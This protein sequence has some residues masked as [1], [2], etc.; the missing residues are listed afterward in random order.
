MI[1]KR[2]LLAAF[3]ALFLAGAPA[4][5]APSPAPQAA[6]APAQPENA[7]KTEQYTL[8]HDRYEKAVAFSR[9]QYTLYFVSF[10]YG[11]LILLLVLRLGVAAQFRNLA[12]RFSDRRLL[13][14]TL[15]VPLLFLTLDVLD[16]PLAAYRHSLSLRYELSVQGWGSW[17]WDWSK[18]EMIGILFGFL[19]VLILFAVIR[20]SPRRCW[21]YFW[22]AALPVALAAFFISPWVIDPLFNKFEPLDSR[23]PELVTAIEKVVHRAGLEIPR[24]KLF[25]MQAS[26]KSNAINAYVTGFGA[27][28]RVVVWDT[29]I[30]KTSS[31]ETLFVFGHEMGHY[32]LN[33]VRDGFLFAAAMLLGAFYLAFRGLHWALDGWGIL[34]KVRGDDDWAA[35][36]VMLGVLSVIL[37]FAS[38]VF[39]GFSRM[40]EAHADIYG[41]EVTHGLVPDSAEVAA[42]AFQVL[43]EVDLSD[44][45]PPD[46]ITFWLY[47]HPPMADRLVFAHTYDP[48]VKR[49]T[50]RY[51]K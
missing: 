46:F 47:S 21:L 24:E 38:P 45:N 40:Q 12:E 51:V 42:H 35:L 20:R 10:F 3:L 4:L 19:L 25:L 50:P 22:M 41:L 28:K 2:F 15:F 6:P 29:T 27:S 8:S 36:P 43:G 31:N 13:Q 48:W 39:N 32:V 1:G 17:L 26:L 16:L 14:A 7:P 49:E 23:H 11:L 33:H 5:S 30:Q 34:W 44:P 18:G 37:F 9:S